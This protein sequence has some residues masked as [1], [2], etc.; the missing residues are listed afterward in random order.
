MVTLEEN[1][2]ELTKSRSNHQRP[3]F[4]VIDTNGK[5]DYNPFYRLSV[6]A[7]K[8]KIKNERESSQVMVIE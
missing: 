3:K 4:R 8:S 5:Y 7:S 6:R 1:H 2:E